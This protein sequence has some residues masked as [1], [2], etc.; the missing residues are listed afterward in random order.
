M[1]AS[2]IKSTGTQG[3]FLIG[4]VP[5]VAKEWRGGQFYDTV[6]LIAGAVSAGKTLTLFRD[7]TG[8]EKQHNNL[9][10]N[11]GRL[12]AQ[13]K[14]IIN[15]I[16][17]VIH[18]AQG[19]T[20]PDDTDALKIG[21]NSVLEVRANTNRIIHQSPTFMAPA[22]LGM[23]GT[24][25][26]NATGLVTIGAANAAGAPSLLVAQEIGPDDQLSGEFKFPD[27][28]G[29]GTGRAMPTT[30]VINLIMVVLDGLF[31]RNQGA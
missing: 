18:Q 8:K 13:T 2:D 20:V 19:N 21:F 12:P 17:A 1:A 22:G 7:V 29:W 30:L 23:P 6:E 26:R 9:E 14:I 11:A 24:T 31:S 16:G 28:S 3:V 5:F 4:G 25:T 27:N 10:S 15:R